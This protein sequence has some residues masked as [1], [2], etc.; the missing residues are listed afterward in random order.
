[1]SFSFYLDKYLECLLRKSWTE[2]ADS[3]EAVASSSWLLAMPRHLDRSDFI[4]ERTGI[5][6]L[7]G[8]SVGS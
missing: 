1:M 8:A 7:V 3:F 2:S 5:G 4:S 6:S